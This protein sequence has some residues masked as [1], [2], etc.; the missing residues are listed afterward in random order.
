MA[1]I[2]RASSGN[3]LTRLLASVELFGGLRGVRIGRGLERCGAQAVG[4][5]GDLGVG[6]L[7]ANDRVAQHLRPWSVRP[8][9]AMMLI[10]IKASTTRMTRPKATASPRSRVVRRPSITYRFFGTMRRY[11]N[12]PWRRQ[13][14][15]KDESAPGRLPQSVP[16]LFAALSSRSWSRARQPLRI[17]RRAPYP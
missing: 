7:P 13:N 12:N 14:S 6:E 2:L 16:K 1:S 10:G 8:F 9:I 5:G 15:L 17:A 3:C 4:I 11:C